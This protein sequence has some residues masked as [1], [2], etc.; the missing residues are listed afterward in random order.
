MKAQFIEGKT[1]GQEFI[2]P[3]HARKAN[4]VVKATK[5]TFKQRLQFIVYCAPV[6]DKFWR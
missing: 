6:V 1:I 3:R 4:K 5:R 2:H